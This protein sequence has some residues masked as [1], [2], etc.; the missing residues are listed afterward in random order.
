VA[1]GREGLEVAARP[2][3]EIEDAQRRPGLDVLEEGGD[4]LG[5]VVVARA[6]PEIVGVLVVMR[7]RLPGNSCGSSFMVGD[8]DTV[9]LS[10][11]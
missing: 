1:E 8:G 3:A 10:I 11:S 7:E 5:D 2:A 6:S 4:V 9:V